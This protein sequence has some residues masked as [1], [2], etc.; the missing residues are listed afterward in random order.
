AVGKIE[1]VGGAGLIADGAPAVLLGKPP[2]RMDAGGAEDQPLGQRAD[3]PVE[4]L[5]LIED[6]ARPLIERRVGHVTLVAAGSEVEG[7]G[8]PPAPDVEGRDRPRPQVS[9]QDRPG[10]LPGPRPVVVA[11]ESP[12]GAAFLQKGAEPAWLL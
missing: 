2:E 1:P 7:E 12:Q 4:T 11:G 9:G 5:L 3:V 8:T 6:E 10:V